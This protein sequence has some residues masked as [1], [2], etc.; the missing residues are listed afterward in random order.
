MR[1]HVGNLTLRDGAFAHWP[2]DPVAVRSLVP[3]RL[4]VATFE[5]DAWVSVVAVRMANVRPRGVPRRLGL[6]FPQ[7]NLR[8]YVRRGD[9]AGVYFVALDAPDPVGVPVAR[10]VFGLP[11]HRADVSYERRGD[12]LVLRSRRCDH[13]RPAFDAAFAPRGDASTAA[14]GSLDAFLAENYR[15]F[16]GGDTLYAGDIDHL[17]WRTREADVTVTENTMFEAHGLD[18]SVLRRPADDP[19][20]RMAAPTDVTVGRPRTVGR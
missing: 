11:Y 8:T 14:P 7:R 12:E 5:G 1:R 4:D 13:P 18:P 3:D 10:R 19:L 15:F 2:A 16:A 6:S 17:P 20:G 9:G